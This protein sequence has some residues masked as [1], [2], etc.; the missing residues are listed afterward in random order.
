MLR[1]L[2]AAFVLLAPTVARCGEVLDRMAATVNGR[3]LLES[4][5]EDELRYEFFA[6]K[7][8][9]SEASAEDRNGALDRLIDQELLRE[10]M[11]SKDFKPVAMEDLT[12]A[13]Q[14]FKSEYGPASSWATALREY[15]VTE[16]AVKDHIE[17]ELNQLRLIDLR[18]RPTIQIDAESVREYYQQQLLP[19]LSP[20]QHLSLQEATP[21]IRELLVQ[22]KMNDSLES[23]LEALRSQA[24]I[25]RFA[26]RDPAK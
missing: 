11:G 2:I 9:L 1:I 14:S 17:T 16:V 8:P 5:I 6:A 24:K 19:K 3:A 22:Q 4:D 12:K 7:R 15:D 21:T 26:A 25:K 18:L 23:W 10:Q 20:G 13:L